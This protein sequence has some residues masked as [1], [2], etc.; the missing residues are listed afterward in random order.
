MRV[1]TIRSYAYVWLRS[2][3]AHSVQLRPAG[4][5]ERF[6]LLEAPGARSMKGK[7]QARACAETCL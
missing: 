5:A 2:W 4:T 3:G 6:P 1:N 7:R